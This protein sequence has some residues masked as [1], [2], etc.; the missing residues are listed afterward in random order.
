MKLIA[1]IV[2]AL[3]IFNFLAGPIVQVLEIM[4][5]RSV[6]SSESNNESP[7]KNTNIVADTCNCSDDDYVDS[8]VATK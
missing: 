1:Q 8:E 2:A 7:T 6:I 4:I 5:I 3:I